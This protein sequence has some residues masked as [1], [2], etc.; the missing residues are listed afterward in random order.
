MASK[1]VLMTAL[2][3]QLQKFTNELIEMY[4]ND[5]D[6]PLFLSSVK[7]AKMSNPSMVIK[8][9]YDATNPFSE[10]ILN[11]DEDFFIQYSFSEFEKEV[12]DMNVFGKL[13]KYIENMSPKSKDGVWSYVQN[14]YKLANAITQ[15]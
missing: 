1:T 4:P 9:I 10:K 5:P 8:S 11:R 12:G 3:E 14:I 13:K 2:F 6:F 7:L 15:M